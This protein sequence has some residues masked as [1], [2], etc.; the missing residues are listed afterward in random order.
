MHDSGWF[1]IVSGLAALALGLLQLLAKQK[2]GEL[3]R[4]LVERETE[5]KECRAKNEVLSERL[6]MDELETEKLRGKLA[7]VEQGH[8][9]LN[10]DLSEIRRQQVPRQEWE[11]RMSA[12]ER[13][14][15]TILERMRISTGTTGQRQPP[16]SRIE[17][18]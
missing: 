11:T 4:R 6:R 1:S 5:A 15:Q 12:I 8:N 14:L 13:T 10:D 17:S 16:L 7:L 3:E 18:R 2:I 9:G